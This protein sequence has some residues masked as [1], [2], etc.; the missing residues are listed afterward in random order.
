[1]FVLLLKIVY[2][3]D[4]EQ[5]YILLDKI[6][7]IHKKMIKDNLYDDYK[8]EKKNSTHKLTNHTDNIYCLCIMNDGRI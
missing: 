7:N 5:I 3:I 6:K 8:I 4:E 2:N 1:M